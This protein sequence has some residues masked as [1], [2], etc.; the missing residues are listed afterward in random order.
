[1][2]EFVKPERWMV[3]RLAAAMRPADAAEVW[4]SGMRTP[5]E[6]L[7]DGWGVSDFATV[8]CWDGEPL[9]MFGLVKR[10]ILTGTGTLWMLGADTVRDH[11]REL[12]KQ[13]PPVI[14]EML[15]ICPRLC[16]MVH[17]KNT[18]S[19]RWLKW[20]GFTVEGPVTHGPL[21]ELFHLFHLEGYQDV[22]SSN[23]CGDNHRSIGRLPSES[24]APA[25]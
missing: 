1:M 10:D 23:N 21:G 20:L 6:S 5:L 18:S 12:L 3:E 25:G 9:V 15:T 14:A 13:T 2:I 22:R 4:A 17:N 7:V 19:I 16:N 24:T 8:A 11:K